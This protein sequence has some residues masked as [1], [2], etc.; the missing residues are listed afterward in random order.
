M[1]VSSHF[2]DCSWTHLPESSGAYTPS[3]AWSRFSS[4]CCC[5]WVSLYN[6]YYRGS[7]SRCQKTSAG[8]VVDTAASDEANNNTGSGGVNPSV[9]PLHLPPEVGKDGPAL[10]TAVITLQLCSALM[11][12]DVKQLQRNT[13]SDWSVLLLSESTAPHEHETCIRHQ[14]I[15]LC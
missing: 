15:I 8:G 12:L 14:C 9:P 6:R 3:S 11:G 10:W 5:W 7:P 4:C 2:L 13:S 1:F